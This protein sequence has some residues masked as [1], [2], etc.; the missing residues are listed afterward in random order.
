MSSSEA[1]S[2]NITVDNQPPDKYTWEHLLQGAG[3]VADEIYKTNQFQ[4]DAVLTF[5]GPSSIFCGLVLAKLK[6]EVFMRIPV[7]TAIFVD[8]KTRISK[9]QL[10]HFHPVDCRFFKVLVP[11]NLIEGT[12]KRI[13]V[14]DDLIIT[15]GFIKRLRAFFRKR[16]KV[17]FACCICY[18]G[19]TLVTETE[20]KPD[21][22]GLNLKE[23]RDEFPM[24]WGR[25]SFSFEDV[26]RSSDQIS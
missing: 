19:R 4:F 6:P 20:T 26:F 8:A 25:N 14:I 15:G 10:A 21:I 22:I 2:R 18:R 24:P 1:E 11:K 23:V 17:Q 5:P 3:W 12:A 9:E 7:Y 13:V 16:G